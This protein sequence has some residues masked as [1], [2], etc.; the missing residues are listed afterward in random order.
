MSQTISSV[1]TENGRL[2]PPPTPPSA[3]LTRHPT[4]VSPAVGR[5]EGAHFHEAGDEPRKQQQASP[6]SLLPR[7]AYDPD[8]RC[9]TFYGNRVTVVGMESRGLALLDP[10]GYK[11]P[12]FLHA[13]E[14]GE[15]VKRAQ[16]VSKFQ[17]TI[18]REQYPKDGVIWSY[19]L[20]QPPEY[21]GKFVLN[22]QVFQSQTYIWLKYMHQKGP[23]FFSGTKAMARL[24][25]ED[26]KQLIPFLIRVYG[27][28]SQSV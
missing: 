9:P 5:N 20:R 22:L 12:L 19:E 1:V 14:V 23:H 3:F 2:T 13:N 4:I 25:P 10:Q 7:V 24:D 21:P 16:E 8:M 17:S 6:G 18:R 15:F 28:P 26:L 11:D 27:L